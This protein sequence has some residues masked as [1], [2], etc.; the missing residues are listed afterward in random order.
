MRHHHGGSASERGK[1][2]NARSNVVWNAGDDGNG[3]STAQSLGA[4]GEPRVCYR[5]C[6]SRVHL[7]NVRL[8]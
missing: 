1:G 6:H 3:G 4:Y 5:P 7:G 2:P 8:Q